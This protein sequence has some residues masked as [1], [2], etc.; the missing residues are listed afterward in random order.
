MCDFVHLNY[1]PVATKYIALAII[2]G[3]WLPQQN[4]VRRTA[5]TYN[6]EL[7]PSNETAALCNKEPG[8]RTTTR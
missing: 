8:C 7:T 4:Y 5:E 3:E 1:F 6:T 2:A